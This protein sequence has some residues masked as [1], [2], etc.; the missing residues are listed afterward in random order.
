[1]TIHHKD[2]CKQRKEELLSCIEKKRDRKF[3]LEIRTLDYFIEKSLSNERFEDTLTKRI[4][5]N[6]PR[7]ISSVEICKEILRDW[8]M[9]SR[10]IRNSTK[11]AKKLPLS[12][13]NTSLPHGPY[14]KARGLNNMN[15]NRWRSSPP[16]LPPALQPKKET[17][18]DPD[19]GGW[20]PPS[21]PRR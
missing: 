20:R 14:H 2:W 16:S 13:H 3:V 4:K 17:F 19:L 5:D 8:H 6:N 1:M 18:G 15:D 12:K 10:G 9:A 11:P 7:M 21:I